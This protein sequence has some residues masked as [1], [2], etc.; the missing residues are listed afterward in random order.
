MRNT[1]MADGITATAVVGAKVVAVG[2][3]AAVVSAVVG[4]DGYSVAAVVDTDTVAT[5]M[6]TKTVFATVAAAAKIIQMLNCCC[7]LKK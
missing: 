1:V 5:G 2:N 4:S 6:A 3:P 7:P